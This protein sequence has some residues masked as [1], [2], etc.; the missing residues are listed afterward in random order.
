MLSRR[1]FLKTAAASTLC[2]T[3]AP[4]ILR[5]KNLNSRLQIAG[6]GCDGKGWSDI[7]EMSTHGMT[8][9]VA[10]CDVDLARTEMVHS[11]SPSA[12]IFQDYRELFAKQGDK[13]DAVTISTPDHMHAIIAIEAMQRGKHVYCQKPLTHSVREAR[14]LSNLA[15]KS[16]VIT[17]MGNQIH[18]HAVYRNAAKALQ[19]GMIGKVKQVQS[20][21]QSTGHGKSGFIDRPKT[22]APIPKSLNWDLWLGVAPE[23]PY[24]LQDVYHPFGW[25]DWQDFGNGALGDFGCHILDPVYTGLKIT[26]APISISAKSTG[27]NDEVWPAQMTVHYV[28]PGNDFTTD[29]NLEITW[30][31]GGLRPSLQGTHIPPGTALPSSGSLVIGETGTLVI[32]HYA[33]HVLYPSPDAKANVEKFVAE[34]SLNHYHGWVD[35]CLSGQQPSDGFD[36][37]G[38]L[39][40]AVLLGN[41]A[42]RFPGQKLEWNADQLKVTNLEAANKWLSRDYRSGWKLPE[43]V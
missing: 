15:T 39:T 20:W 38:R 23:R 3:A 36:Y 8:D 30:M 42:V 31:D 1:R 25:R 33:P 24:G 34:P 41:I 21:C 7:Q 6:I 27:M 43:T 28:L 17:R 19:T 9:L 2:L 18:S 5:A 37:G 10:F 32:P 11:L 40:E 16:G 14:Q 26:A 12:P 13:I 22:N 4:A 35:G 29:G